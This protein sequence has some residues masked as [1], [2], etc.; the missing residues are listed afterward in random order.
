MMMMMKKANFV[1]ADEAAKRF[2]KAM[3]NFGSAL[4]IAL[5]RWNDELMKS[6]SKFL[7]VRNKGSHVSSKKDGSEIEL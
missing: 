5:K 6:H 3:I 1:D 4:D 7:D 2:A